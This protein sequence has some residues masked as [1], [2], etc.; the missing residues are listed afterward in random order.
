MRKIIAV[1]ILIGLGALLI[2][3]PS[4]YNKRGDTDFQLLDNRIEEN[5]I[6]RLVKANE[7][8]MKLDVRGLQQTP[9]Q[10][11]NFNTMVMKVMYLPDTASEEV[12]LLV[13]LQRQ[14]YHEDL[15]ALNPEGVHL[16]SVVNEVEKANLG[17][18]WIVD[19]RV[20]APVYD[21][22]NQN[23]ATV[24]VAFVPNSMDSTDDIFMHYLLE[25]ETVETEDGPTRLWF[26]K[27]WAGVDE[28]E[29]TVVE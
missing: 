2:I 17:E 8:A 28:A 29:E 27:G 22:S 10:I 18:S 25:R 1:L 20:Y 21:D 14:Y 16:L 6:L 23:L 26:I 12:E 15:L 7:G 3:N 13:K 9:E 11:M 19:Y 24:K 5:E 4:I